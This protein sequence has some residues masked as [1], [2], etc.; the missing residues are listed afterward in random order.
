MALCKIPCGISFVIQTVA[1]T[2]FLSLGHQTA[3]IIG[4]E[5]GDLAVFKNRF[6]K[7][8]AAQNIN[9]NLTCILQIQINDFDFIKSVALFY[10]VLF[11][12]RF[13]K[14]ACCFGECHRVI[15]KCGWQSFHTIKMVRV[16]KLV[17]K[18]NN[19]AECPGKI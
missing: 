6:L 16:S 1:I 10:H 12:N 7:I 15:K 18:C 13:G 5:F 9:K 2:F 3:E 4:V 17:R 11:D 8:K 19:V 14:C